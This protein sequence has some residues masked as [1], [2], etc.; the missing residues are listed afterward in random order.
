MRFF[1]RLEKKYLAFL[2]LLIFGVLLF[3]VFGSRGLVQIFQM[4]EEKD[5]ILMGNARLEEENKRLS[6]QIHR[7]RTDKDEIER[8]AREEMMLVGKGEIVYQFEK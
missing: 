6:E 8:I 2:S 3:T 4:R 7:L 5:R 1:G